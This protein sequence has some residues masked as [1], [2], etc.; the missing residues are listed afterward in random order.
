MSGAIDSVLVA[1]D[2]S[3]KVQPWVGRAIDIAGTLDADLH[4]L[5]VIDARELEPSLSYLESDERSERERRFESGMEQTVETVASRAR[6]RLSGRIRTAVERGIPFEV[7][8]DYAET[9]AV[10]L[11]AVGTHGRGRVERALLGSVAERVMRTAT[12]P[13][14]VI[15]PAVVEAEDGG[16]E[17][18]LLPTDGSENADVAVEFG[19]DLADVYDATVH[20]VYSV[21]TG[22]LPEIGETTDLYAAIEET[23]REA[24]ESVRRRARAADISVGGTIAR[25]PAARVILSHSEEHD[26]DL[27]VM[28]THGRSGIERHLIGSVTE[29]VV[30]NAA[31]PVC[32]VPMAEM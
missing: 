11:I 13:V 2:G 23:G 5:S 21:D 28:G 15:P 16:Y 3:E 20:T 12:V 6:T 30:R 27:I 25:G 1:V 26:V 24:L 29:T 32:C 19:L 18:I 14:L 7:I 22:R 17:D 31:V 8:T 4:V 9:H 10:D